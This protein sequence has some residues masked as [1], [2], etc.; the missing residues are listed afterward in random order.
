MGPQQF[1]PDLV[2]ERILLKAKEFGKQ[3]TFTQ[4]IRTEDL[5][6]K[7]ADFINNMAIKNPLVRFWLKFTRSPTNMFK[8]AGRYLPYVNSPMVVRFPDQ[9]PEF[10]PKMMLPENPL[11]T[12]LSKQNSR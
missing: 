12:F 9:L 10:G 7:G 3:I 5:F 8:E 2:T 1:I 11:D 6:G 4:D